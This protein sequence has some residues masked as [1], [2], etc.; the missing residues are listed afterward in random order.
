MNPQETTNL[1]KQ[2]GT[3]TDKKARKTLREAWPQGI[4]PGCGFGDFPPGTRMEGDFLIIDEKIPEKKA[5]KAGLKKPAKK[6][7]K[8]PAKKAAK[9]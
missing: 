6:V 4:G 3:K 2:L 9:K 7:A 5:A 1:L 8:K